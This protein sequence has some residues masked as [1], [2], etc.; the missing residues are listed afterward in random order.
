MRG[1]SAASSKA[2]RPLELTPLRSTG[3]AVGG[4]F[5]SWSWVRVRVRVR[6]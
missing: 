6:V 3:E 1:L 4:L 5:I 2:D